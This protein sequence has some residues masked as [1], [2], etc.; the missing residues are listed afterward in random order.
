MRPLTLLI[1]V[2]LALSV[3]AV[4][5]QTSA[6]TECDVQGAWEMVD[7]RVIYPDRVDRPQHRQRQIKIL[8]PTHFAFGR[9][10]DDP[11][12]VYAGGGRYE[13]DGNTYTEHIEYHSSAPLVGTAI[14]FECRVEDDLWYHSGI[15]GD[16]R[17]EETW[18]RI[19][20]AATSALEQEEEAGNLSETDRLIRQERQTSGV[21]ETLRQIRAQR[22][23]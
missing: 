12:E 16:F 9:Q 11:E 4:Y 5:G 23:N 7:I 2:P 20:P 8:T 17:L 1:L 10:A 15:I 18:R 13:V 19:G 3:P 14:E 6:G 22:G 21:D